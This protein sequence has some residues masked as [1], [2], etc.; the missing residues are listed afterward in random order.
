MGQLDA[1]LKAFYD[2]TIELGIS[3]RVTTFTA[4][5][6][7]RTLTSNGDGTDHAWG[8]HQIIMGGAVKGGHIYG[9]MPNLAINSNDDIGEG[10]I[11]PTLSMDQYGAT[12]ANWF[13]LPRSNFSEVFPN[14]ENFST[15]D[16]GFMIV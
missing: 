15:Q 10:R 14:L 2:T 13:G 16:L 7:G 5:D 9:T 6:F 1:A 12:L 3:D 11:I 8:N 4:S